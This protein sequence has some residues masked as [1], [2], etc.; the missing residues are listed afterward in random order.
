MVAG[1]DDMGR[2]GRSSRNGPGA[3]RGLRRAR[4]IRDP[5]APL[6]RISSCCGAPGS[7]ADCVRFALGSR[8]GAIV[9][10]ARRR[11]DVGANPYALGRG[12]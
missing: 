4:A 6:A 8:A 5:A 9:S 10:F 3:S 7:T 1:R 2:V 12:K 11:R